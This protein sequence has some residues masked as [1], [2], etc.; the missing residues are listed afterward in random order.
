[1][2]NYIEK[3]VDNYIFS[4]LESDDNSKAIVI[5]TEP[6]PKARPRFTKNGHAYNPTKNTH[7]EQLVATAW[8]LQHKKIITGYIKLTCKFFLPIAKSWSNKDKQ[9]AMEGKKRPDKKPDTDNLIKAVMD[10]LNE[11][12]WWDDK[13]II[14]IHAAKFYAEQPRVEIILTEIQ[15]E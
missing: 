6:I 5:Y 10:A 4:T 3:R 12:A 7:Y 8:R 13:Q 2:N 1:M 11:V 14:E 9:A 15:N